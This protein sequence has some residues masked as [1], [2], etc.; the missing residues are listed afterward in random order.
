MLPKRKWIKPEI[1]WETGKGCDSVSKLCV[2]G[3]IKKLNLTL[4]HK[5]RNPLIYESSSRSVDSNGYSKKWMKILSEGKP[6]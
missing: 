3:K 2:L 6:P 4:L 1:H 5:N